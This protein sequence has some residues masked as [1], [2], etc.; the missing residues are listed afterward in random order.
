MSSTDEHVHPTRDNRV[1][2]AL[3]PVV[4]GPVGPRAG[5]GARLGVLG[6]LLAVTALTVALGMLARSACATDDW[7]GGTAGDAR[8]CT[9]DVA[10][11]YVG[12]GLAELAWP[13]GD[14]SGTS[15]RYPDADWDERPP[16]VGVVAWASAH[17]THLVVGSPDVDARYSVAPSRLGDDPDV[18][19][20][21]GVLVAVVAVLWAWLAMLAVLALAQVHRRRPWDAAAFAAAPV[22]AL[23]GLVS[24][25]LL[26]VALAAGALLA[27]VRG[28]A[29]LAG[30]ALGA[31]VAA[32]MWPAL[33]LPAL[34]LDA[35][36]RGRR[37]ELGPLLLSG[38]GAFVVA[39]LPA[40]LSSPG[41]FLDSWSTMAGRGP[42][43]GTV[44][45]VLDQAFGLPGVVVPVAWALVAVWCLLVLLAGAVAPRPPRVEQTVLLLLAGAVLLRTT[46]DP[47][48]AVWLLPFAALALP[49][50]RDQLVWQGGEVLHLA[51]Y[52][53]WVGGYLQPGG[54]GAAGFYWVGVLAHV[55]GT[56][57]LVAL[58]LRD[59][60]D[61]RHDL[62]AAERDPVESA[63]EAAGQETTTAS[64]DVVV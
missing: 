35:V 48:Q 6:V 47:W 18:L 26:A 9:S 10:A 31:G 5:R 54:S 43:A 63:A 3:S 29:V 7:S 13:W 20:E 17:V 34:V 55:L 12:G 38:V 59:V 53:W 62:L 52:W 14:D 16:L 37:A 51:L 15:G 44:W 28:R 23:A 24:W 2:R 40:A 64:N 27:W 19:H 42:E 1:L 30:L 46:Y 50:W 57:W 45:A 58:V 8:L 33:L 32:G 25:D 11:G 36:R 4:G 60:L 21:R 22:L 56:C 49:R 39:C 61:P 41:R